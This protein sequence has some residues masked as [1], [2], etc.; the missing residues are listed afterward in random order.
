MHFSQAIDDNRK[1][2]RRV[3]ALL[4]SLADLAEEAAGRS[5]AVCYLVVWLLHPG[6]AIARK[7][8]GDLAPDAACSPEQLGSDAGAAEAFRLARS[9]RALADALA[10]FL[11]ALPAPSQPA[12]M[13][14]MALTAS[15]GFSA[16]CIRAAE[17]R[18]TS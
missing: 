16:L 15:P 14:A 11:C 2:L 4:L 3:V 8:L 12:I 17:R 6:E 5:Q 7:Y 1:V 18:D 9:F 13:L 10:W